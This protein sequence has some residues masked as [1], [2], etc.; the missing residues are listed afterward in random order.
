MKRSIIILSCLI[1]AIAC[2]QNEG[3]QPDRYL[4]TINF[5]N[6]TS[7]NVTYQL[8]YTTDKKLERISFKG[9]SSS[10]PINNHYFL[11]YKAGKLDS[12]IRY[13]SIANTRLGAVGATWTGDR[14]SFFW[15]STYT[16]DAQGRITNTSAASG[17]VYRTVFLSDSTLNYV[18]PPG[19]DPEYLSWVT[20]RVASIKNPFLIK[21]NESLFPIN[22]YVFNFINHTCKDGGFDLAESKSTLYKP[23]GSIHYITTNSYTGNLSNYPTKQTITYSTSSEVRTLQFTYE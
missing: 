11:Q 5:T 10:I 8:F 18:D 2:K 6:G 3:P 23:D 4:S 19:I 7:F 20:Y 17:N 16:Y 12:I 13:D 14:M 1:F 15:T 21:G 9:T 22:N